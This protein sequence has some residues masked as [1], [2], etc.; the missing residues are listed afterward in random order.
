MLSLKVLRI[1]GVVMR[2]TYSE[3][4]DHT[5]RHRQVVAYKKLNIMENQNYPICPKSGHGRSLTGG[6]RLRE[7]LTVPI[8]KVFCTIRENVKKNNWFH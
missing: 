4:R 8:E 6:G 5:T 7:V 2:S 1:S 3:Q